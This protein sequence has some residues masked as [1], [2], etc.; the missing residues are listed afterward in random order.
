MAKTM[1]VVLLGSALAASACSGPKP[2]PK[3]PPPEY[4][5]ET[6]LDAGATP[7]AAD[8]AAE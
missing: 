8:A 5:D 6:A 2:L 3:G 4:E 7:P 1:L